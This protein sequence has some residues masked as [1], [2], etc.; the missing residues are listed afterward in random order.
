[1]QYTCKAVTT[2]ARSI[3]LVL[4]NE[5]LFSYQ[6]SSH[7]EKEA[8]QDTFMYD[9]FLCFDLLNTYLKYDRFFQKHPVS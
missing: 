8:S 4:L 7:D 3:R 6:R 2:S 5:M 9:D 1:M